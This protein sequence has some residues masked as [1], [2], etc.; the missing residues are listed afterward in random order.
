[1]IENQNGLPNS[2]SPVGVSRAPCGAIQ[3]QALN[4][5]TADGAG[6]AGTMH[7]GSGSSQ[8]KFA[9]HTYY[10][11]SPVTHRSALSDFQSM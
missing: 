11:R 9:D 2:F 7:V 8:E 3:R 4:N 6:S 1:M 5:V 10:T